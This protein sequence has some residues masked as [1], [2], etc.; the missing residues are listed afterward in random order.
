MQDDARNAIEKVWLC[1]RM[2]YASVARIMKKPKGLLVMKII[3]RIYYRWVLSNLLIDKKGIESY[4]SDNSDE[5]A[6]IELKSINDSI[7][8]VSDKI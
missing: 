5:Q 2:V 7:R 3:K 6:E 8:E 4:L 1:V